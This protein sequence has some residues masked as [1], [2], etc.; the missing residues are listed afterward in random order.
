MNNQQKNDIIQ[1]LNLSESVLKS[2]YFVPKNYKE[3]KNININKEN[4]DDNEA[5]KKMDE[6]IV[7]LAI[8]IK[9]SKDK[10]IFFELRKYDDM[11]EV[12]QNVCEKNQ[13]EEQIHRHLPRIIMRALNSVYGIMNLKLKKE[14]IEL[15]NIIREKYL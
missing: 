7:I 4:E 14:E 5:K 15:L 10:T 12:I 2:A 9:I 3:N 6:N 8:N 13:I 11:F 1:K